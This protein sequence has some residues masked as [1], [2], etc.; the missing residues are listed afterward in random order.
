MSWSVEFR[1]ESSATAPLLDADQQRVVDHRSGPLLVLAGPGTGKTTT[2]VEAITARMSG[3]QDPLGADQ[4]LAL[5]FGRRAALDLRERLAARLGGGLLP[6]VSTFHSFA[7]ALMR[8]AADPEQY[9]QPPR[10]LS[11]AEEDVRIRELLRGAVVDGTID[12]PEDLRGALPTLGLANEVRAAIARARELGLDGVELA[13]IG[14][15]EKRPAWVAVGQLAQ[16]EQEVMALENVVDYGELLARA[17]DLVRDPGIQAVLRSRFRAIY[18]DEYQ[19]T[20]PL[21]V[22]LLRALVDP[23]TCFVAVGDPDQAIYGFRGA[24]VTG[25]L[26]FPDTFRSESGDRADIVV[27][28]HARRFGPRIRDAAGAVLGARVPPGLPAEHLR[29]HRSPICTPVEDPSTDDLVSLHT[30]TDAGAEAAHVARAIRQAHVRRQVPWRQMAV[31]VRSAIQ[32]AP[33]QRALRAAGI[34]AVVAADEIPLRQEPAVAALL[35]V[36]DVAAHPAAA[37]PEQ[38]LEVLT[39][40]LGGVSPADL[41]RL[42]RALRA[43]AHETG[44]AAPSS[45]TLI[46]DLVLAP[47]LGEVPPAS[48]LPPADAVLQAVTRVS[49]LLSSAHAQVNRGA[50]PADVL[51]ILWSGGSH[52]WPQRLRSAALAGDLA[53]DHDLDAVM[54]LFDTAER[55]AGRYP[56]YLGVRTFVAMLRDQQIPAEAVADRGIDTDAVRVLTAHRAKGLEWDEIW[57]VGVQEGVWPDLRARG[58]TLRVEHISAQG[59]AAPPSPGQLLEEERR[60]LFVA[61]TRARHR[62]HVSAV[63]AGADSGDQ[64]SRLL[65]DLAEHLGADL[66]A[67]TSGRPAH[68]ASLDGLVAELRSVTLDPSVPNQLRDAAA[69]RLAALAAEVDS[70][71]QPLV[72]LADPSRWWG[73][74]E[75]TVNDRPIHDPD[76]PLRV[77]GSMLDAVLACPLKTFLEQQVQAETVRGSAASFGSIVHAVA[78]YVAKGQVPADLDAMDDQ[79]ERI[80]SELRFEARW[81]SQ[82]ERARARSALQRFLGYHQ[83]AERELIATEIPL[84][85]VVPVVGPSGASDAVALSG[86]VDRIE[87]DGEGRPVAI[88]LKNMKRPVPGKEVPEHGQLGVYQLLLQRAELPDEV[89]DQASPRPV[90]GAALVQLLV[91][92]AADAAKVQMQEALEIPAEGVTWVEERLGEAAE[93]LRSP[94]VVATPCGACSYCAYASTCPAQPQGEQVIG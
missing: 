52:G 12:W 87:R 24:D 56:G 37:S 43:A 48:A 88:D 20:D 47:L 9:E 6:T 40:P 53:A 45:T 84:R 5:T 71:G 38:V 2:I 89:S 33:I 4:V 8:Q 19:D 93:I 90:G 36:L 67:I 1:P 77:S 28:R 59:T 80:W 85:V 63:D 46:R 26:S 39:G 81:Q 92:G 15:R 70:A 21:Q 61:C 13:R 66:D 31:L 22:D 18:V 32:I 16:Q 42:G 86:K 74:A 57:V 3:E 34:P 14:A 91:D 7:Y 17:V 94:V 25:L 78:E 69:A 23:S 10:L 60:L 62:L 65:R 11:G 75:R 82:S 29:Q 51:W 58:T 50:E 27:L 55:L 79:V 49:A 30:Y 76:E 41:R 35:A 68:L 73:V 44:R 83:D 54:A 64:P 72:P